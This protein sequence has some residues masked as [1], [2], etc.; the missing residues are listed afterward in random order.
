MSCT[1]SE[2]D[3]YLFRPCI[4]YF[5]RKQSPD[6]GEMCGNMADFRHSDRVYVYVCVAGAVLI[7]LTGDK[8][9]FMKTFDRV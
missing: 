4:F 6:G 1:V 7:N 5:R 3:K 9:T 2:K 8:G